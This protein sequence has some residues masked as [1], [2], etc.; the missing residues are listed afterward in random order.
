[1]FGLLDLQRAAGRGEAKVHFKTHRGRLRLWV[2]LRFG[3]ALAG[4]ALQVHSLF[5]ELALRSELVLRN[6]AVVL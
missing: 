5:P 2:L 1:M 3:I 4:R 6:S